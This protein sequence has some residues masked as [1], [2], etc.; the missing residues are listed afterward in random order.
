M[1]HGVNHSGSLVVGLGML[2]TTFG[3]IFASNRFSKKHQSALNYCSK[4]RDKKFPFS[5]ATTKRL[6]IEAFPSAKNSDIA[7]R[8]H[9]FSAG[10]EDIRLGKIAG[11]RVALQANCKKLVAHIYY[12]REGITTDAFLHEIGHVK[13]V[14]DMWRLSK[15]KFAEELMP[16]SYALISKMHQYRIKAKVV[17]GSKVLVEEAAWAQVDDKVGDKKRKE[18]AIDTYRFSRVTR[19]LTAAGVITSALTC[20]LCGR[21]IHQMSGPKVKVSGV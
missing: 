10:A 21:V 12:W 14:Y 4:V 3:L 18:A 17:R 19:I 5:N 7:V 8:V 15:G 2:L 6:L 20:A 11:N 1:V 9:S 13:D 16:I